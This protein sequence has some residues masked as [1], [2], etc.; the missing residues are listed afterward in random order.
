MLTLKNQELTVLLLDPRSAATQAQQGTRYCWGGYIW[1]VRDAGGDLV[2]GPE[3]PEPQPT[4]FNGQGLPEAF[5]VLDRTTGQRLTAVGHAGMVIGAGQVALGER[6]SIGLLSRAEWT[7]RE[8]PDAIEF[9]TTQS[10]GD[11]TIA[12]VRTVTLQGREIISATRLVNRGPAKLPLQW[13][14]HPFFQLVD[15]RITGRIPRELTVDENPGFAVDEGA[16][17][18]RQR[19]PVGSPG[20]FQLLKVAPVPLDATFTHPRL[21]FVRMRCDYVATEIPLWANHHTFSI[22]PYLYATLAAGEEKTWSVRYE[23]GRGKI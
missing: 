15:G 2:A 6:N 5:R 17:A 12:L 14:P 20:H 16:F 10:F 3:Y 19:F 11:W 7:V 9:A 13:F 22:E 23:F 1:Q 21:E 8:R 18:M 4:P